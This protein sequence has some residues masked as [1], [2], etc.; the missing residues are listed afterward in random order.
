MNTL[1]VNV[2]SEV[3][4]LYCA[5]SPRFAQA[6]FFETDYG[7]HTLVADGSQV[8]AV[9]PELWQEV[10]SAIPQNPELINSL[11]AQY[12][13]TTQSFMGVRPWRVPL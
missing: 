10:E 12:G 6:H 9:T 13:L 8:Y 7:L 2:S 4:A 3:E 5:S 11:L 1:A